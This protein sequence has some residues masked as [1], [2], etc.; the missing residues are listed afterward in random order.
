LPLGPLRD[1]AGRAAPRF[2]AALE[3]PTD[4]EVQRALLAELGREPSPVVLVVEDLHWVDEATIDVLTFTAR[5]IADVPA[6]M[7]LTY[8]EGEVVGSHPLVPLLG[9]V[10]GEVARRITLPP[11]SPAAVAELVGPA[12][13][14]EVL[15]AT[16]GLPFF[17]TELAAMESDAQGEGS[18]PTS[19]AHAVLA[20]VA[21]LPERTGRLLD[22]LAVEPSRM[23]VGLLDA[24][25][26][27]W[28]EDIEPA[29][30]SAMVSVHEHRVAF[31]HELARRSVLDAVPTGRRRLLHREVAQA[32]VKGGAD[33][34][35]VV[36]HAEAG[37]DL[38]VLVEQ[39]LLAALQ[40]SSVSAHREGWSQYQRVVP[41]LRLIAE[42]RRGDVLEAAS[43]EA[44]AAGDPTA[45][46][47]LAHRALDERRGAGD[48]LGTGRVH[49]WMSRIHW[50]QGRRLQ[51]EVQAQLA[52][53]VLE[54]L[55]PSVELAWA[56]SNLSQLAMLAWRSDETL[57]WGQQSIALARELGADDVLVHALINVA[58]VRTMDDAAD[59]GPLWEAVAKAQAIGEHH[60]ATRGMINVAYPLLLHDLPARAA[61]VA[62]RALRYA[63]Q[64]EVETLRQ[65]LVV[66][67]GRIAAMQG[68][69]DEAEAVL[70]KAVDTGSAVPLILALSSLALV[71]V[72]RGDDEA[73]ATLERAWPLAEAAGEPQRIVPL[74]EVEAE[75]AWLAD[76]L[77]SSVRHLR[78]AYAMV[79]QA[80]HDL[81][82]LARW[83]QE[84]GALTK[85]PPG[86]REPHRAELEGRW[87]DAA[88][89]WSS[90]GMPYE[91]ALALARTGPS[92][93]R[94]AVEIAERLGAAPLLR[95]LS[96]S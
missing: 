87:A 95:R 86:A 36:H 42:E 75:R 80:G 18:L 70:R 44:Y 29:E 34:A 65:Y 24:L 93:R 66:I 32:L 67:I 26:P 58:T 37:G 71:Q 7:V 5:R 72:R 54:P 76:R 8:R 27:S 23:D 33:P 11:L 69:W 40:A 73:V 59:D 63:E 92:G 94:Q 57:V 47:E 1:V 56:Y 39:A 64:H 79:T 83:L 38:D 85:V 3:R 35:R 53:K 55:P 81:G 46:L 49:R 78:D 20:R 19:V 12:R 10:P 4:G 96:A 14:D 84:A 52:V 60:E 90:R 77:D 50:Y 30:R 17:V 16:A 6:T 22:L 45:A 89:D 82:R 43:H 9:N 88:S 25:R 61:E 31:R 28:V 41:L 68:R 48:N 15:A 51:S 2:A 13:A 74:A 21:R 62:D 91:Q